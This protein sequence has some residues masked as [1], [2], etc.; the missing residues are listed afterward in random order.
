MYGVMKDKDLKLHIKVVPR[1]EGI[2]VMIS[3]FI[4]IRIKK[5]EDQG[6]ERVTV[7]L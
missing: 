2:V 4:F 3:V 5:D 6:K 7:K 1:E